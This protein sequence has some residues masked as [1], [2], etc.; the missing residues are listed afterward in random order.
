MGALTRFVLRLVDLVEAEGRQLRASA[1]ELMVAASILRFAA[2]VA[3]GGVVFLGVSLFLLLR[4]SVGPP[5]AAAL[6]GVALLA[7]AG[8]VYFFTE[9][10]K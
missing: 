9:R 5:G 4:D 8:A 7:L 1:V 3:A 2:L 6:S 10:A